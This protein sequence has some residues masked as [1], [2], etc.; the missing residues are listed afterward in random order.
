MLEQG[1]VRVG[2][3]YGYRKGENDEQTDKDEAKKFRFT[4]IKEKTVIRSNDDLTGAFKHIMKIGKGANITMRN[5]MATIGEQAP[6]AYVYCLTKI[7][8]TNIMKDFGCD[9]GIKIIDVTNTIDVIAQSL[10]DKD[11]VRLDENGR[12]ILLYG[13]CLYSGRKLPYENNSHHYFIKDS[14]YQ[15]Q[16]EYRF[17]FL[18]KDPKPEALEPVNITANEITKYIQLM[19]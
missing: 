18:P 3:L 4:K 6:D 9:T 10:R 17:V 11:L 8:D 1:T 7:F 16:C 14:R 2:T 12:V 15:H 19:R 5:C 13:Q